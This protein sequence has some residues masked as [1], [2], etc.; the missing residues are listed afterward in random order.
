M[1][2]IALCMVARNHNLD[3]GAEP[4]LFTPPALSLPN[5]S[6]VEGRSPKGFQPASLVGAML[7]IALCL[8]ARI[9]NLRSPS[10]FLLLFVTLSGGVIG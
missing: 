2:V 9:S 7:V 5:G 1:L 3:G 8:V 10:H 6:A 4:A